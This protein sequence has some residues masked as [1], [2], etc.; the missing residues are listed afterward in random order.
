[1]L[2]TRRQ[3]DASRERRL[4]LSQVVIPTLTLGLTAISIPE[5]R[6]LIKTKAVE[7][8]QKI[9]RKMNQ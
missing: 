1:M 8:K 6:N 2:K 7:V 5:V 4:W 3:I 9:E